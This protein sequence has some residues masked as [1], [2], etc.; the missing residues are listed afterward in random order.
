[1][2]L[3]HHTRHSEDVGSRRP[4]RWRRYSKRTLRTVLI[5]AIVLLAIRA[6]LPFALK[7]YVNH[8][9]DQ[10]PDYDAQVGDIDVSLWRGA[11]QIHDVDLQKVEGKVPVPL[12]SAE[13]VDLS[14]QWKELFH[15]ALVGEMV[16]VRPKVNFVAAPRQAQEQTSVDSVWVHQVKQLF[17]V[18]INRLEVREGEIHYRDFHTSP[19]ID[20][21]LSDVNG[22]ALHLTNRPKNAE[23]LFAEVYATGRPLGQGTFDLTM[24]L[25]PF[26]N[27][28][29]FKLE[30]SMKNVALTKMNDFLKA[31]GNFDV[32]A[33]TFEAYMELA[34]KDGAFKGYVKPFFKDL[35]VLSWKHDEGLAH[36]LWE[37]A[38]A[39]AAKIL[40]NRK[41]DEVATRV[42]LSGRLDDPQPDTWATIG[43][44]IR[45]AFIRGFVPGLDKG[46][47]SKG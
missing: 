26:A 32:E 28:I 20:I 44:L 13:T 41:S 31:Y 5:V 36:K 43:G 21:V 30:S 11:Y 17:P 35:K 25:N 22:E 15:G 14:V 23:T 3:L 10:I 29:D 33:G 37:A 12:F 27:P 34:A 24:K 19:K 40:E 45:N 8:T 4:S 1:M 47:G 6:V 16:F 9:L 7:K 18:N 46:I 38:V 2:N 42:P 39:G